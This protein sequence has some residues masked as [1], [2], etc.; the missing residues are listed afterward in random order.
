[1]IF[2]LLVWIKMVEV[3]PNRESRYSLTFSGNPAIFPIF[4]FL[5]GGV[6]VL[7]KWWGCC[8]ILKPLLALFLRSTTHDHI[9]T[10]SLPLCYLLGGG[11]ELPSLD[12]RHSFVSIIWSSSKNQSGLAFCMLT[13]GHWSRPLTFLVLFVLLVVRPTCKCERDIH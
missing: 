12:F 13:A 6:Y 3:F 1:M 11:E 4:K 10:S 9:S 7:C 2:I 8:L 5:Y